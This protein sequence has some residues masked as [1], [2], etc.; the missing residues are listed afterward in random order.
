MVAN[1]SSSEIDI[2]SLPPIARKVRDRLSPINQSVFLYGWV[3]DITTL[4]SN[5]TVTRLIMETIA[6]NDAVEEVK[7]HSRNHI[8]KENG[9]ADG[10]H[11]GNEQEEYD[12]VASHQS[13]HD[14]GDG[15]GTTDTRCAR[16]DENVDRERTMQVVVGGSPAKSRVKEGPKI[17]LC[18]T[19]RS[20][21]GKE[22]SKR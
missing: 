5:K 19:A 4:S 17:W 15:S 12:S 8:V 13:N 20:L 22:K 16:E 6:E 2:I 1:T 18:P 3:R 21:L 11:N 10:K 9:I 7:T 14:D